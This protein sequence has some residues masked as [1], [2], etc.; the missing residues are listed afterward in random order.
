MKTVFTYLDSPFGQMLLA[1]NDAGLTHA[2][3]HRSKYP[4][5][6][7]T[8]WTRDDG[9][10][11]DAAEQFDAY[12]EGALTAFDLPL[13]PAGTSFQQAVWRALQS[14]PFGETASYLD[15]ARQIGQ[16]AAC[17]A[18]GAA[19][20]RNPIAIAI[21]CHRVI[22]SNGHLTGYAGGIDIKEALLKLEAGRREPAPGQ[23]SFV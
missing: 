3:F 7:R 14:I 4:A 6:A 23:L 1:R 2:L 19:N 8:A 16:P 18:V 22:G 20:G 13:A 5:K 10:F 12:F 17:R 15:I 11:A 9:A 21:P